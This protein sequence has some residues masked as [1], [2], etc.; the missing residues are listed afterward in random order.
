MDTRKKNLLLAGL[1]AAIAIALYVSAIFMV[2]ASKS[3]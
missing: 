2:I 1:I 3:Q